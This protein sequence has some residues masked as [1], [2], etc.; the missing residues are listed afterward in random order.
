MDIR[1]TNFKKYKQKRFSVKNPTEKRFLFYS[2]IKNVVTDFSG[3]ILTPFLSAVHESV[4]I[5]SP[6]V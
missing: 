2:L 5:D 6:F 3:K 1:S 4:V